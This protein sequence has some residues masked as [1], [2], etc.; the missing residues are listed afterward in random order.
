M[1]TAQRELKTQQ[2]LGTHETGFVFSELQAFVQQAFDAAFAASCF[3]GSV[4]VW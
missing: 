2:T 1:R 3:P 4:I